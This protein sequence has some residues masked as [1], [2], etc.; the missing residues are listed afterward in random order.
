[1]W[2]NSFSHATNDRNIFHHQIQSAINEGLL[3]FQK[4]QI[5]RESFFVNILELTNKKVLVWLDVADKDKVKS[6]VIDE[7][8][9][10]NKTTHIL[11]NKVIFQR[12]SGRK[13]IQEITIKSN[14]IGGQA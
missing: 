14:G 2:H 4:M 8:R 12:N 13:E 1:M 10:I 3:F 11:S 5:D 6:I 9:A 7:P